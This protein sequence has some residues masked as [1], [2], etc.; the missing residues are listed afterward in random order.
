MRIIYFVLALIALMLA[1]I[2]TDSADSYRDVCIVVLFIAAFLVNFI[3]FIDEK[4]KR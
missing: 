3:A 4:K 1:S 2:I